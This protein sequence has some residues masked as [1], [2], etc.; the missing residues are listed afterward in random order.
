MLEIGKNTYVTIA[1]ADEIANTKTI[2]DSTAV[3]WSG[4]SDYEKEAFLTESAM[5]IE[6]LPVAGI[7]L[8]YNQPLQFPRRANFYR[9]LSIPREVKE[10]QV[11]N[12][13]ELLKIKLKEG[14]RDGKILTSAS[15]ELLLKRWSSG[16]FKLGGGIRTW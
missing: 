15:A 7:K 1:E 16:G 14:Q 3:Y 2:V 10:A 5:E 8:F 4:L 9:E 12:A 13:I 11:V 6:Q